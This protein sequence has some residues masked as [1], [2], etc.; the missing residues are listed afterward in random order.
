M[1]QRTPGPAP[2]SSPTLVVL[3]ALA[4]PCTLSALPPVKDTIEFDD[5]SH[6]TCTTDSVFRFLP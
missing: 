2:T 1:T 5:F 4:L 6:R 3:F